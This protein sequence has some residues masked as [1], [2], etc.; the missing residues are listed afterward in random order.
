[1]TLTTRQFTS[2]LK[3]SASFVPTHWRLTYNLYHL[4]NPWNS[5]HRDEC[6]DYLDDTV[7]MMKA[8]TQNKDWYEFDDIDFQTALF[9]V[10]A[11]NL[12]EISRLC[13]F[14]QLKLPE[15]AGAHARCPD[16]YDVKRDREHWKH[17]SCY[18]PCIDLSVIHV[19][20]IHLSLPW[21]RHCPILYRIKLFFFYIL[22][23][24]LIGVS[25]GTFV[26]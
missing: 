4:H 23:W 22:G 8:D 2:R 26:Y 15:G 16:T 10:T 5:C 25:I 24:Y 20:Q 9:E 3:S 12:D 11:T 14:R 21:K 1:M 18:P 7:V 13:V 6:L 17:V 19:F